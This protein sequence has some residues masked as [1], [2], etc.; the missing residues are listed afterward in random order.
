MSVEIHFTDNTL[1]KACFVARGLTTRPYGNV[2]VTAACPY[3]SL[4]TFNPNANIGQNLVTVTIASADAEENS[5]Y[6][7]RSRGFVYM[8]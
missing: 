3:C 2:R 4:Y 8:F 5:D 7:Y 1:G 6:T